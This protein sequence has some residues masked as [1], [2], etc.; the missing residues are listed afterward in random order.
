VIL[1]LVLDAL[2]SAGPGSTLRIVLDEAEG[3]ALLAVQTVG[4]SAGPVEGSAERVAVAR[5]LAER[6]G[7]RV[8]GEMPGMRVL[9]V[10][11]AR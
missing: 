7:A 9:R 3:S 8:E 10:P 11:L 5:H 2:D 1:N 4:E 6:M